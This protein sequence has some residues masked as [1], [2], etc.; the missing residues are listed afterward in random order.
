MDTDKVS[1]IAG[2]SN[3]D[4][5]K[6]IAKHLKLEVADAVMMQFPDSETF[7]EI[8]DSIRGKECF[9]IQPLSRPVNDNLMELL[10]TIDVIKRASRNGI[11]AVIPYFGYARQ[12]RKTGPKTPISAKLVANLIT[13]AGADRIITMDLHSSQIQ[14]FFDMPVENMFANI[15]FVEHIKKYFANCKNEEVIIISPDIGGIVRARSVAKWLGY[16]LA[17]IDKRRPKPGVSEVMNI[18]GNVANKVCILMDD[19]V[20]TAGSLCNAAKKLKE[21]GAKNIFSYIT[22]GVL[23]GDA[24]KKI[25]ESPIEKIFITNTIDLSKQMQ[26]CP[27]IEIIDV[28]KLLAETIKRVYTNTSVSELFLK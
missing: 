26:E 21:A 1:I 19:I 27:K 9:I 15:V 16:D 25:N 8:K 22:H 14:G 13:K 2:N 10:I 7:V 24:T 6:K 11:T 17:I 20:D 3:P 12:D 5:C 23:S 28:S 18:I 4:L